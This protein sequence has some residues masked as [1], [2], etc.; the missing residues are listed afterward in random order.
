MV[1]DGRIVVDHFQDHGSLWAIRNAYDS[2]RSSYGCER[3]RLD[4]ARRREVA[5]WALGG[6]PRRLYREASEGAGGA[7]MTMPE[8]AVIAAIA[9]AAG[10]GAVAGTLVGP[11]RSASRVA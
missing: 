6:I 8:S 9:A 1:A 3:S 7:G 11:G 5:R 2:A 4:S 10:L